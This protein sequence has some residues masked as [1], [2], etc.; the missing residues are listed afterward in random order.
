MNKE[1]LNNFNSNIL[2]LIEG[3]EDLLP[4]NS[5]ISSY[6]IAIKTVIDVNQLAVLLYYIKYIL[7]Y[8]DHINSNNADFFLHFDDNEIAEND[9]LDMKKGDLISLI[10]MLKETWNELM[11]DNKKIIFEYMQVLTVLADEYVLEITDQ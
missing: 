11:D 9:D 7:P 5:S 8:R 10:D 1:I 3:I 4:N 6:S 2:K